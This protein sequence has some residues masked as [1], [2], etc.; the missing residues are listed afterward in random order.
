MISRYPQR[1][2]SSSSSHVGSLIGLIAGLMLGAGL[3]YMFD[4]KGGNRRRALVRDKARHYGRLTSQKL[5]RQAQHGMDRARGAVAE[6]RATLRHEP[7]ADEQLRERVRAAL[8]RV[9]SHPHSIRVDVRDCIVSLHGPILASEVDD[10]IERVWE[11]RGVADVLDNLE[12][13]DQPGNIPG[14]QRS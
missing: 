1:S 12:V 4:P 3:M 11:V 9:V 10:L 5:R 6:A 2:M 14:L 13:Y 7:V 8:G